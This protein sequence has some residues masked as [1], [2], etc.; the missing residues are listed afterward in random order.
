MATN[1]SFLLFDNTS[2]PNFRSWGSAVSAIFDSA[3]WTK[4]SDTGQVNWTTVTTPASGSWVYEIRQPASDP[5]QTGATAY[6]IKVEYGTKTTA[7]TPN[8]R[9]TIGTGTN[10]SGTLTG[11]VAGPFNIL[12]N[13]AATTGLGLATFECD[14]SWDSSRFVALM[15]RTTL[16]AAAIGVFMIERTKNTDGTDSSDGVTLLIGYAPSADSGRQQSIIF[17]K[18]L[19]NVSNGPIFLRNN[20]LSGS[21]DNFANSIP[22]SPVYPTYGKFGNPHTGIAT[23]WGSD[24]AEGE[25]M[26]TLLYGATRTY[27]WTKQANPQSNMAYGIRYD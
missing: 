23:A 7:Q 4:T 5:L 25:I 3:G 19:G 15:W 20:L 8:M 16:N 9:L 27:L 10:G 2:D 1:Q 21:T 18:G 17:G 11:F 22:I 14:F 12:N 26:T 24:V 6:Y 13:S